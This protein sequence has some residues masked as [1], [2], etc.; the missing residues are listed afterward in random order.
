MSRGQSRKP[1]APVFDEALYLRLNPDVQAA[2]A[3][4]GFPS[5]LAHYE[6]FGR[7]EG[8]PIAPP[9]EQDRVVIATDPARLG[10][11]PQAPDGHVDHVKISPGGGIYVIGWIND[12]KDRLASVDLYFPAWSLSF[13]AANLARPRRPDAEA[14]L[15][16]T[17]PHH[18]GFWGFLHAGR[19]LPASICNAVIRLESGAELQAVVTVEAAEDDELRAAA[20]STIAMAAY[21]GDRYFAAVQSLDAA[22][23]TQLVAFNQTLTQRALNAPYVESFGS[24]EA[25]Y[26][27]SIIV[28]LFGKIE[29]MAV[30]QALFA[31]Q[32][33]MADYEFI[34][35]CNS[36]EAAEPL[37]REAKIASL[38]YGLPLT[39]IILNANAGFAAANN[40][41]AQYARSGRLLFVNPDVF[42]RDENWAQ[43]H[44]AIIADLPAAQTSLFGAPLYYD[45]GSLMHGGMYF[46]RDTA[47]NFTQNACT[48]TAILRVEHYGKG[49]P[50]EA[51][52]Y[53]RPRAVPAVTGAFISADRAWF[54]SLGGFNQDYIFGHYED[55]DLCLKSFV[56]GRA[57][58]LQPGTLWHLEGKGS[59]RQPQHEGGAIVNRWLF[60]KNWDGLVKRDL[61]GPAPKKLAAKPGRKK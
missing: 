39:I 48:E 6:Q 3:T 26:K 40:L 45:D 16:L 31:R 21:V 35:V 46:E 52:E 20:L 25:A 49:A 44:S 58:W 42:P 38:I 50:P 22:I 10:D 33:G 51:A 43:T 24:N 8:R 59:H 41:A 17:T 30:Q 27:G 2:V 13:S 12:S 61:L 29:L 5:G 36:P 28:C 11:R 9:A 14:A 55:A 15:G 56:A 4:G 7:A 1:P 37:L 47:P 60:T 32:A 19:K 23:G 18:C 53:L 54:E 34:Y 57:S